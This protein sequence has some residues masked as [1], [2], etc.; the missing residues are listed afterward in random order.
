VSTGGK[1]TA[2][3]PYLLVLAGVVAGLCAVAFGLPPPTGGTTMGC[4]LVAGAVI[5]LK[6]SDKRAG[7]LVV[8]NRGLDVVVLGGLGGALVIG[9]LLL[10]LHSS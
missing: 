9:S 5:R 3:G 8:R 4:A 2:W 1:S 6:A 7:A 10:L